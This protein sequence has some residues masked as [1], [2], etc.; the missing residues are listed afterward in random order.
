M[1]NSGSFLTRAILAAV[2]SS[3]ALSLPAIAQVIEP[4]R[5]VT[6]FIFENYDRNP[7]G[8]VFPNISTIST[9]AT[10]TGGYGLSGRYT[11]LGT[12]Y[13]DA[14]QIVDGGLKFGTL[15]PT[16]SGKKLRAS[17][18]NTNAT[19]IS[20]MVD[21]GRAAGDLFYHY[22][23]L[24]CSFLINFDQ[25]ST[26]AGA[27]AELRI[28]G[29]TSNAFEMHLDA[30]A[31]PATTAITQPRLGYQ[32]GVFNYA[33]SP[34]TQGLAPKTTY[35]VIAR[36]DQVGNF[37][38]TSANYT[39]VN[40][41]NA[42]VLPASATAFPSGLEVGHLIKGPTGSGI[43]D[44]SIVTGLQTVTGTDNVVTRTVLIN[45]LTTA[46]SM[47]TTVDPPVAGPVALTSAIV[48]K[49]RSFTSIARVG[50]NSTNLT[51]LPSGHGVAV[52]Q[53]IVHANFPAG[54]TV[55]ATPTATT[56]TL[57]NPASASAVAANDITVT[58][59]PT[60]PVLGSF[61]SGQS[62]L[63]VD[64]I[65]LV[66]D[67]V[68]VID[69]IKKDQLVEGPGIAEGTVVTAVDKTTKIVSL[70]KA[71]V[72]AGSNVAIRFFSRFA[73]ADMWVLTEAQYEDFMTAGGKDAALKAKTI[74]SAANQATVIIHGTQAT[75]SWEFNQGKRF[76]IVTHGTSGSPQTFFLDEVRFAF[77]V[78]GVTTNT[79]YLTPPVANTVGDDMNLNFWEVNDNGF[80]WKS[81]WYEIE[82]TA[83]T[84]GA[85]VSSQPGVPL[86][87]GSGNYLEIFHRPTVGADQGTRRR[88]DPAV[89]DMSQP[90]TVKFD[91]RTTSGDGVTTFSD[92]IQIGADG[93]AGAGTNLGPNPS[94]AT[95][96]TWLVGVVG[97]NDG[98]SR[99]FNSNEASAGTNVNLIN[100]GAV[101]YWYFF[102]FS[103]ANFIT[104]TSPNYFVP[105]NMKSSGIAYQPGRTYSFQIEVNPLT[106]TYKA[107]VTDRTSGLTGSV[108]NLKFRRQ[109][110]D[111]TLFWGVS[112][113][114]GKSRTV[115]LDSLRVS[116]GLPYVD[117]FPE[118]A[119][120]PS[121][122][123]PSGSRGR[124]VD[125]NGDG[126][127]NFLDFALDGNPMSGAR[128][129]KEIHAITN[130]GGTNYYTLTIPVRIGAT[131]SATTGPSIST[132]VDGIT[133]RIQG[134]YDLANWTTGP[135]VVPLAS[136]LTT[137]PPLSSGWEYKSFRLSTSTTAQPKA[138]IRA[139][140]DNTV[141]P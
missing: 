121:F 138:F 38:G 80:G 57:S 86:V 43:P 90:Y 108:S 91:Y 26:L 113:P 58:L 19:G 84:P 106:F 81:G 11:S 77:Q 51:N 105:T 94:E 46:D 75:G 2:G 101:P 120:T 83:A 76:E 70:S 10:S 59:H 18:F 62:S 117:P 50:P 1:K 39:Y 130:V 45:R 40:N 78:Q 17:G 8:R 99:V 73:T 116:Q 5:P 74:G 68:N 34:A 136:P 9:T 69:G 87:T 123:V 100:I 102:D 37:L 63:T 49:D 134:S 127:L 42:L 66:V 36:F 112:K 47:N 12:A 139:V 29:N 124:N 27:R 125:A 82:E 20:V 32:A 14:F 41:S 103:S 25:I 30:T 53:I 7:S 92:R 115:A 65:P 79:P 54:T 93:V 85:Y 13:N 111:N 72:A 118:W 129:A 140:V 48:V 89:V 131:F 71:T 114:A 61:S 21:G 60:N 96:L 64:R 97:G 133:Y 22:D 3:A 55:L 95:N 56:A 33:P 135:D 98:T 35:L 137:T 23:H 110:P 122:G 6:P 67:G 15:A 28:Q 107:T 44:N 31:S 109:V 24:Y 126:R 4:T 52:G 16:E 104:P 88:P 141:T 119:A 132:Q 128:S